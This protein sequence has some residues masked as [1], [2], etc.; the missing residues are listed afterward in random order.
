M[1][2]K[3]PP[4]EMSSLG[5][6]IKEQLFENW[7]KDRLS[8]QKE[9]QTNLDS[10]NA[11]VTGDFWKS[12]ETENWRSDT[13][14]QITKMKVLA[15]YSMVIDILLQGGKIPF[16]LKP[17]PWDQVVFDDLPPEQR[18]KVEDDIEDMKKLIRQQLMDCNGDRQLMMNVM[19]A[20]IYG[21]TYG[22][23]FVQEVE[24]SG[25]NRIQLVE[26]FDDPE[27]TR[28][29]P[30]R[31]MVNSP[32][33]EY[34]SNWSI[35]RDLETND[36]Q[37]GVGIIQRDMISPYDLRLMKN[38]PFWLNEP[39]MR[40]ISEADEPS[41][42]HGAANIST[43]TSNLPP[44]LRGIQHRQKTMEELEFWG[45]APRKI[46]EQFEEDIEQKKQ[47]ETQPHI[48]YDW[49]DYEIDGDEV[50]I[51]AVMADSEIVRYSR[52]KPKSR[53]FYRVVWEI[54][55]DETSGTGIPKN[56]RPVQ[57]VI[58]GAVRAF[59]DNKKLSA[60]IMAAVKRQYMPDWDG[61]F[62]PGMEIELSDECDDARKAIAQIIIQDVG[63]TLL[64]IINLFERYADET[65]QLPKILQGAVHAK[66]KP[67]TLGEMNMLQ[68][69]AGKYLGGVIKNFD[70]GLIEPVTGDFYRYNMDD[71]DIKKGKGNYIAHPLGFTS[72][73][74]QVVRLQKLM[75][76]LNL[77][78]SSELLIGE[79]KVPVLLE[80]IWKAFDIDPDHILK[81]PE[82]KE[83]EAK[84]RAAIQAEAEAKTRQ[85]M[86]ETA[87][88]EEAAKNADHEREM[89]KLIAGFE[90]KIDQLEEKFE[91]DLVLKKVSD[92]KPQLAATAA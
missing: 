92:T 5:Y 7:K 45:R 51:M 20:A 11:V 4:Q 38:G 50:E 2:N 81:S 78:L 90:A 58:N 47:S 57:K 23:Y 86:N 66:E 39:I 32:A 9:M 73:Q 10:F 44:G 24:R 42:I 72:F 14:V 91:N 65:S 31:T 16:T 75:Q 69:N 3:L 53:P 55:L 21:E 35:F 71:P 85:I 61:K 62:T 84:K 87:A 18:K 30:F 48:S 54:A 22:K 56:L 25:F 67:D 28:W 88:R 89:K 36:L 80:E 74:N 43:D 79:T 76:G 8:I 49:L 82:E 13:F 15:A 41:G 6:Y 68:A 63:E 59:E 12:G 70:E 46:V 33:F 17:S 37:A 60:N 27:L 34:V 64:S 52:N 1:A 26:G 29:E 19:A 83:D 77:T 40:A